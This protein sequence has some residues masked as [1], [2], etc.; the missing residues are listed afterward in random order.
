MYVYILISNESGVVQE[1]I[2]N[3]PTPNFLMNQTSVNDFAARP[4]GGPD[5]LLPR[6]P[7]INRRK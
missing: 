3:V 1:E 7:V 4:R 5:E 2:P 6:P